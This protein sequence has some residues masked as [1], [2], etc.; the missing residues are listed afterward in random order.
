MAKI[1]SLDLQQFNQLVAQQERLTDAELRLT[2]YIQ[3]HFSELIYCSITDVAGNVCVSK[4]TIGR[5]LNKLGFTG[6]AEFKYS[7]EI[8]L[9][10]QQLRSPISIHCE[11]TL[12][13]FLSTENLT[14]QFSKKIQQLVDEFIQN[15]HLSDLDKFIELLM[16]KQKRVFVVGPSSSFAM[17]KHFST[18]I[19]YF[20]DDVHCLSLDTSELPKEML[21]I[22]ENDLLIIFSYYRFNNVVIDIGRW[23]K[24]Y[25]ATIVLVTN[26]LSNPYGKFTDIQFI[27]PSEV[28]AIFQSRIIGFYFVELVLHLCYEKSEN[29]GNF[30]KLEELF[31]YFHTFHL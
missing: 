11:K 2:R 17:A 16:D 6:Y 8:G 7:I 20:R 24:K 3:G 21:H 15:L 25:K 12:P 22:N 1:R 23:F 10:P 13:G 28:N 29:E 9:R 26:T 31:Q 27:M 5:Y 4:A 18:L 30:Q 14:L 19:K